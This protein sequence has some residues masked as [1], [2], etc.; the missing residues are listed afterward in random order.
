MVNTAKFLCTLWSLVA[1]HVDRT[2]V[3]LVAGLMK[4]TTITASALGSAYSL[5]NIYPVRLQVAN[6]SSCSMETKH[7]Q[8]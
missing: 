3:R 1:D 5:L 6:L 8:K 7:I 2:L 4:G